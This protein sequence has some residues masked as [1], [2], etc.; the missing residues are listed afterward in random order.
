MVPEVQLSLLAPGTG[1]TVSVAAMTEVGQGPSS[2]PLTFH[3]S[4]SG[5]QILMLWSLRS[6]LRA[7]KSLVKVCRLFHDLC[8]RMSILHLGVNGGD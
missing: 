5:R 6:S 4:R 3:T 1:Y 2:H 8:I 7:V